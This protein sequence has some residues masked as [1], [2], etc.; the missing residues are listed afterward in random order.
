MDSLRIRRK[1]GPTS[2]STKNHERFYPAKSVSNR[3]LSDAT[4]FFDTDFEASDSDE[5]SLRQS[6]QSFAYDSNTTISTPELHTPEEA[7][8]QVPD[9]TID[10][11]AVRG[12]NGPH[13]FRNSQGSTIYEP[14]TAEIDLYFERSPLQ[15]EFSRSID[16]SRSLDTPNRLFPFSPKTPKALST[17]HPDVSQ[18]S[19]EEIRNWKTSQVAHWLYIA[20]YNDAVI[21]KFI[22][23]DISGA[24]LLS[25]QVDD[26]K[27]LNIYSFGM[28]HQIM[29][30]IDHLKK[31]MRTGAPAVPDTPELPLTGKS[32]QQSE[33]Q[34]QARAPPAR[35]SHDRR[36][37][38]MSVSPT[39]E[40]LSKHAFG[41]I[42]TVKG[43]QITPQESVSIVGIE[44]IL[45]KPHSC[46]KGENC[47]KWKRQQKMLE[48]FATEFPDAVIQEGAIITGSPGNP[49]TARNLLR[50]KS[51]SEP[52][53]VASSDVLGPS[54][55]PKLSL[56]ALSEVK[57]LDP[58]ETVRNF[59]NYQHCDGQPKPTLPGLITSDIPHENSDAEFSPQLKNIAEHLRSLP[60][61]TIPTT[62]DTE[63]I[64]TAVTTNRSMTPTQASQV[65]GSPTAVQQYGPFSQAR[66][67]S[68]DYYRQ[69]TPF[70]EMDVPITAIPNGPIA[71][72][73]SQSVPPD[74]QYGTL[75]PSVSGTPYSQCLYPSPPD[76]TPPPDLSK[77]PRTQQHIHS[78]S[79]SSL[80]SDPDVTH[81]G[82]M[83]KRKTTR[84]LRHEWQ[85]AHFT[86]RG[87]HIAMHKDIQDAHR[88]SRALEI[89]DVDDYAVACSSLATSSKLTAAFKRSI[90][91][92]GNTLGGATDDNAFAFSLIPAVKEREKKALF[93]NG[94]KSHHFAVKSREQRIEWMRTVMLAKVAQ[95][96]SDDEQIHVNGV[97]I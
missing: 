93:G 74:M 31:T 83:K 85:D 35:G 46:S 30:S 72:D 94:I 52:S 20:G 66:K 36:S 41:Q 18:V 68:V 78:S 76:A 58:Q 60:K 56:E 90:L 7:P 91:R 33:P 27:E 53:V 62:P 26:L 89:I 45:P 8:K 14:S 12:P 43:N 48:K 96:K 75:F 28:R 34:I 70:S 21:E 73:V 51:T 15:S 92:N 65:Y 59:L 2:V 63:D 42:D 47:S 54:Q 64:T 55:P 17:V 40:V 87:T 25:L 16:S 1:A 61:L 44:Q 81:S 80:A 13:L 29:G 5:E 77:S 49:E 69:G 11:S 57:K 19:E 84:L 9:I 88:N 6:L 67:N 97:P 86:L 32:Q 24:V 82:W 4:D 3:R 10:K 95:K 23:N 37:Y 50:P 22:V 38:V 79:Q 71:R 39:G